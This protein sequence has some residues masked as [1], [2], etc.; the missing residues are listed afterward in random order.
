MAIDLST[1]ENG[2]IIFDNGNIS[3]GEDINREVDDI[4]LSDKGF[5]R[6]SPLLGCSLNRFKN[7]PVKQ[8]Q[9]KLII[10]LNLKQDNKIVN[11]LQ[12][13][14]GIISGNIEQR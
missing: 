6:E 7:M 14:N 1:D 3:E 10:E 11:D 8:S 5:Y 4:M 9:M 12:I 13:N 2:D